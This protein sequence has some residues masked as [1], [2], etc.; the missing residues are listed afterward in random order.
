MDELVYRKVRA[1][2]LP[3]ILRDP[4]IHMSCALTKQ[5]DVS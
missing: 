1:L 5:G 2:L 3:N 4:L